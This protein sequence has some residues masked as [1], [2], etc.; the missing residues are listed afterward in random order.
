VSDARRLTW[1]LDSL[2]YKGYYTWQDLFDQPPNFTLGVEFFEDPYLKRFYLVC[3]KDIVSCNK[4]PPFP[5]RVFGTLCKVLATLS[6]PNVADFQVR[7]GLGRWPLPFIAI[8]L[9][10]CLVMCSSNVRSSQERPLTYQPCDGYLQS[11][12]GSQ[13]RALDLPAL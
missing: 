7:E 11:Q 5:P 6:Y 2:H 12:Q 4:V 10:T 1:P 3:I 8:S 13:D 9:P